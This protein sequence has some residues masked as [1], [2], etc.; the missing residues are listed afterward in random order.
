MLYKESAIAVMIAVMLGAAS[1]LGGLATPALATHDP[2]ALQVANRQISQEDGESMII[3]AIE[4]T[5]KKSSSRSSGT[6]TI[7]VIQDG[8]R[9]RS[10]T[11]A[12]RTLQ[13]SYTTIEVEIPGVNV[14]GDFEILLEYG[15][16]GI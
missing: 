13:T 10:A 16:S 15:G 4:F 12:A 8:D 6:L 7:E 2:D 3:N 1:L 11:L 9:L 5:A 14:T